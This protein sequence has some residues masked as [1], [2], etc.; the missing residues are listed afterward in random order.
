[1]SNRT[2]T[3]A[4]GV[5][6]LVVVA[7]IAVVV[8]SAGHSSHD[9]KASETDGA[10]ITGMVPHHKSAVEMAQVALSKAEHPDIKQLANNIV[11]TQNKEIAEL[12][13]AHQRIFGE[14]LPANGMQHGNLGL[15]EDEMGMHGDA[16][17]LK[18]AKPFDPTFIDMMIPHHQG[19]IRMAR[20]ELEKGDDAEMK[21]LAQMIIDAQSQEIVQMNRWRKQWYGAESPAGGVPA[22]KG[23]GGSGGSMDHGSMGS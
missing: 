23:S 21:R 1:M 11:S 6:A 5:L 13:A 15:S 17:M 8:I 16:T 2:R 20:V 3:I 4:G 19:A 22:D 10:F 9:S 18:D 7:V 12:T 14:P